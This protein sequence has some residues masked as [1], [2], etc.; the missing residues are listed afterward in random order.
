MRVSSSGRTGRLVLGALCCALSLA[1]AQAPWDQAVAEGDKAAAE[2]DYARAAELYKT[3]IDDLPA[4]DP[5]RA[6]PLM[7]L[8]RVHRAQGDLA[9][10]EELYREADPLALKAWGRESA[11]YAAFLNEVGRYYHRRRKYEMAERF[12]RDAF[13]IRV[14]VLGKENV[15]V[16][17]SIHN[18]AVLYENQARYD[19]AEMYYRTALELRQK[20][21]GP[22]N[23]R[24]IETS[25]HFAR[26]LR[27]IQK[28]AEAAPLEEHARAVRE[29]LLEQAAG[30]HVDIGKV[31]TSGPDVK[32]PE[33]IE[34]TE[35]EYTDEAR[36]AHQEGTVGVEV[37][38]DA[39]GVA[40]NLKVVRILGLG[41]DE[42]AL[43]AVRQWRFKPA[44]ANGKKV[45]SRVLLEIHFSLL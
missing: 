12:Y 44:R 13:G 42:K 21:L 41:L 1:Y 3:A 19:K 23:I 15:E 45:A 11:E 18:L 16:A 25:E 29:P 36:I 28:N 30:P 5:R 9:K 2:R 27:R 24:T 39:D 22:D 6:E 14:R 8:A 32:M 40:R 33:L 31:Y 7:R 10:P 17:E 38:V 35:P 34:Q 4:A 37:E 26:L 20:L 43:E